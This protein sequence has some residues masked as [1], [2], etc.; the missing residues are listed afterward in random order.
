MKFPKTV[1]ELSYWQMTDVRFNKQGERR[2]TKRQAVFV[3]HLRE[4]ALQ[5]LKEITKFEKENKMTYPATS[6]IAHFFGLKVKAPMFDDVFVE[7]NKCG[8]DDVIKNGKRYGKFQTKQ[9]YHCQSCNRKFVANPDKRRYSPEIRKFIK[10][11]D[12]TSRE[13]ARK[14]M[15]VFGVKMSHV[16]VIRMR[17]EKE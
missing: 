1:N 11:Q 7:C 2:P 3:H 5:S 8:S 9:K 14:V 12:G 6:W 15:D 4:E 16:T 10:D 17:E 13:I